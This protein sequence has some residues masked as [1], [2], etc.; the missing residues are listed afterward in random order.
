MPQTK[1][2]YT[3]HVNFLVPDEWKKAVYEI[4]EKEGINTS[5]IWRRIVKNGLRME[6]IKGGL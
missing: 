5:Y 2:K 6:E 1:L 4:A 3:S